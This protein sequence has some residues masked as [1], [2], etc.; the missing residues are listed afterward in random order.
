MLDPGSESNCVRPSLEFLSY[1]LELFLR[2][3]VL[4]GRSRVKSGSSVLAGPGTPDAA[5]SGTLP[6]RLLQPEVIDNLLCLFLS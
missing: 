5:G 6:S 3:F 2:L 1:F 4:A